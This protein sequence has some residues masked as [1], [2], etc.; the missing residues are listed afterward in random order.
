MI[1]A[2]FFYKCFP[3]PEINATIENSPTEIF[4]SVRQKNSTENLDSPPP[5]IQTFSIP[6]ISETLK[7][8]PTKFFGT[9]RQK[10]FDGES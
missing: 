5:L 1:V 3:V 4:G 8:S 7:G 6:E 9:V 2:P 10:N